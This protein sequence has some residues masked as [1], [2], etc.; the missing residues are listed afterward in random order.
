V[1]SLSFPRF[2]RALLIAASVGLT[3]CAHLTTTRSG[4]LS[5]Y[6]QLKPASDNSHQLVYHQPGWK[7]ADYSQIVIEP[8][9][10]RLTAKDE[11]KLSASESTD[12]A[13]FCDDAL[14]KAV[15]VRR[16]AASENAPGTLRVRAA[17][18]GV[19]TS[20]PGLNV[21]TGVLL[22]PVD[23]GGISLEFEVLDSVT[24]EQLVALV[25]FS[26]GTP[27]QVIGSFSR[28]GHARSGVEHWVAELKKLIEPPAAPTPKP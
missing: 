19:D 16:K 1:P 26:E 24:K 3:G 28:L 13:R 21:V 27:L 6:S 2:L 25:G 15:L 22:W 12:L 9:V 23:N 20:S 17:V 11:K 5:D 7:P 14:K 4:F 10:V 8:S 18:T